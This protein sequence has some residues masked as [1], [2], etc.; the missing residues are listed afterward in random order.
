MSA[1]SLFWSAVLPEATKETGAGASSTSP[2]MMADSS[3]EAARLEITFFF[4]HFGVF[5]VLFNNAG[6]FKR[7][8]AYYFEIGAAFQARN[9]F[10]FV[11]F[12]F[13]DIQITFTCRAQNHIR[14]RITF[15][16]QMA[17]SR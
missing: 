4:F 17:L 14:L 5:V 9:N 7:A 2:T 10:T 12:F 13:F 3:R 6:Q 11:E 8:E 16:S 15:F 1:K